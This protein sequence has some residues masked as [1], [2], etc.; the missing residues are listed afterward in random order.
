MMVL[1]TDCFYYSYNKA[2]LQLLIYRTL[3]YVAQSLQN[4]ALQESVLTFII[5]W[6]VYI[7]SLF[8]FSYTPP[9]DQCHVSYYMSQFYMLEQYNTYIGIYSSLTCLIVTMYTAPCK[10]NMLFK[11]VSA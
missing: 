2:I 9:H 8:D 5:I 7:C 3:C 10:I 1:D 6:M 4:H 11:L